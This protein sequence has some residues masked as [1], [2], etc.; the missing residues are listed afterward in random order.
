MSRETSQSM[1][2]AVIRVGHRVGVNPDAL[3]RWVK[4]ARIDPGE[5]AGVTTTDR[6]E[7][8]WNPAGRLDLGLFA[9][10]GQCS[11]TSRV[12]TSRSWSNSIAS[13]GHLA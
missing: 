8:P 5:V 12:D 6:E 2:A 10:S 13:E 3:P 1:I 4:Q 11:G 9:L 7:G